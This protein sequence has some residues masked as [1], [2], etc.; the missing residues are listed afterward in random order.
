[1]TILVQQGKTKLSGIRLLPFRV[2][3][4]PPVTPVPKDYQV[5]TIQIKIIQITAEHLPKQ[6]MIKRKKNFFIVSV[7]N[8]L[9]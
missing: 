1:M 6:G 3:K 4:R 5:K 8:L 9:I 7:T 2:F